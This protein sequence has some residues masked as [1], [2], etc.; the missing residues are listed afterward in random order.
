MLV[1]MSAL[2]FWVERLLVVGP[3]QTTDDGKST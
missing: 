1:A 2:S 3:T